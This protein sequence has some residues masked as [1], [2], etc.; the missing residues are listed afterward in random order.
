MDGV[1][2]GFIAEFQSLFPEVRIDQ[3]YGYASDLF[4]RIEDKSV[5]L[6]ILPSRRSDVPGS[7]IYKEILEGQNV[8]ACRVGHP[9]TRHP[10][11]QLSE[12]TQ[13]PWIAP[14]A[15]SPLFHDMRN[16]LEGNDMNELKISFTGG[17]L[18]AVLNILL[19]SDAL[20]VLPKS[21]VSMQGRTSQ[22]KTLPVSLGRGERN[23]G[24]VWLRAAMPSA[25]MVHFRTFLEQRFNDWS[26]RFTAS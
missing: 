12:L 3:S 6:A 26:V 2:S 25:A 24:L 8:V 17:S 20:T 13:Y 19:G 5:D 9:L 16:A 21:V 11:P 1:F 22:I 4:R 18:S 15:N 23:L 7:C 14:P 10:D